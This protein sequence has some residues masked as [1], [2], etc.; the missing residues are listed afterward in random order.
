MHHCTTKRTQVNEHKVKF[1]RLAAARDLGIQENLQSS[2]LCHMLRHRT[3]RC[4]KT[5][6]WLHG[7]N[8]LHATQIEPMAMSMPTK[9]VPNG[10]WKMCISFSLHNRRRRHNLRKTCSAVRHKPSIE[11]RTELSEITHTRMA[12]F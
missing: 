4:F 9:L 11:D 6:F 2:S 10:M 3:H 12:N 1:L 5:C 8:E 7:C